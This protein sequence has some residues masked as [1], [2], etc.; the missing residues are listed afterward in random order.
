MNI[1]GNPIVTILLVVIIGAVA[2]SALFIVHKKRST[3]KRDELFSKVDIKSLELD[4]YGTKEVVVPQWDTIQTRAPAIVQ[5]G[6]QF[7][8]E[9]EPLVLEEYWEQKLGHLISQAAKYEL[10]NNGAKA[11]Q[12]YTI[13]I[14]IAKKTE[15]TL[16]RM[17]LEAKREDIFK[18][19]S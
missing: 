6:F 4:D 7:T 5:E 15:N 10:E 9:E 13:L 1:P 14:R 17:S 16:L 12:L 18:Q 3:K 2:G 19:N 8:S 11:L